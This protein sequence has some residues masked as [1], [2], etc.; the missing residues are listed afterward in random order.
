MI[1]IIIIYYGLFYLVCFVYILIKSELENPVHTELNNTI[2][3]PN[4]GD[5]PYY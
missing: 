3:E 5:S 1:V 2:I 4:T